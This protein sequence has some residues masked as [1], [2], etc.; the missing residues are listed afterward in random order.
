M[1]NNELILLV[2]KNL[3]VGNT[4]SLVDFGT[5]DLSSYEISVVVFYYHVRDYIKSTY[6]ISS[7]VVR[8]K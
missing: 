1:F 6:Y 2:I 7:H 3:L 4:L 5:F 8:A